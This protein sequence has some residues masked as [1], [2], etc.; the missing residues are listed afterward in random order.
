MSDLFEDTP[1]ARARNVKPALFKNEILGTAPEINSLLFVGLWTLADCRG[2][3]EDRPLRI[4]AE[5]F[6]YRDGLDVDPILQWLFDNGFIRR[7][8]KDG[9]KCILIVTFGTHQSPHKNELPNELPAPEESRKKRSVSAKIG[10]ASSNGGSDHADSLS[11]DSLQSSSLIPDSLSSTDPASPRSVVDVPPMT[12]IGVIEF[13]CSGI[14][15]SKW[16][17]TQEKLEE[18]R[19]SFP[20]INVEIEIKKARQWCVDN[21][22]KRKTYNG[23]MKFLSGWLGRAQDRNLSPQNGKSRGAAQDEYAMGIIFNEMEAGDDEPEIR[24]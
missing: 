10:R 19:V 2:I 24:I 15:P 16:H 11:L 1:V 22:T 4:K 8:Q 3:L 18:Y 14:G 21:P 9:R 12:R 7:Y 6:P 5:L 23:V 20:G 17:L 13:P